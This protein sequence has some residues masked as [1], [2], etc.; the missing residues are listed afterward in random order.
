M[1]KQ[2]ERKAGIEDIIA[3][4]AL[5]RPGPEKFIPDF[6]KGRKNPNTI[7]YKCKELKPILEMTYGQI[8]YQEQVMQIVRDLAGYTWGRSD[9]VR[10][11]MSKKHQDEIDAERQTFVYGN[12]NTKKE[13]EAYV[14]G[15]I[16]NGIDED[17]A[18][19][20]W[21]DM[22]DF[23]KYAFNKS[24]ATAYSVT[25]YWTAWL[26]YYY[27]AYY[28][29]NIMNYADKVEDIADDIAD[30]KDFKVTV[31]PP[32]VN[33]SNEK[34]DVIDGNIVY[35]LSN[36]KSVG[37]SAENIIKERELNGPYTDIID[38]IRRTKTEKGALESLI[39]A[40]AF[41]SLG[42][43]RNQI[44]L[45]TIAMADILKLNKTISDKEKFITNAKIVLDFLEEYTNVDALKERI[46]T[47]GISFQITSKKV[48]T[49]DSIIKRINSA[50]TAIE[51]AE[52]AMNEVEID[53]IEDDLTEKLNNEKEVLG[54]YIT[55]HP[56]DDYI[57]LT[58]PISDIQEESKEASVSGVI[59]NAVIRKDK[60]GRDW[61]AFTLE[62]KTSNINAVCFADNYAKN[63]E[64]LHEGE[65]VCITGKVKVD[66]F[67][68][69]DDE[70]VYSI[71]VNDAARLKKQKTDYRII[72]SISELNQ[73]L[74]VIQDSLLSE[75]EEGDMLFWLDSTTGIVHKLKHHVRHD[76]VCNEIL[77]KVS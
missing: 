38:F 6:I 57:V 10:R 40:G 18:H 2:Q 22:V 27:P 73:Y 51:E 48:P 39:K 71:A 34:C 47:E 63:Y 49:K 24:H 26:K 8:V 60:N 5:Y 33:T 25:S 56:L 75:N 53:Y 14:P 17:V 62:D 9:L 19:S 70:T 66:T 52:T 29:A 42:Y 64:L 28:L 43:T 61:I 32:D 77:Q 44:A 11:A 30:A 59:T 3:M 54:L 4:N 20:I 21:D 50:K 12:K 58:N 31:L 67:R 65:K 36:I 37:S 68:S 16:A 76:A 35:G 69:T 41:D 13:S 46:K 7:K 1:S 15:C 55:G 72:C 74:E 45:D 23:A